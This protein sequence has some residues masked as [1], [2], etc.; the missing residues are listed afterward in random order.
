MTE[1]RK[2]IVDKD[3][4]FKFIERNKDFF[5]QENCAFVNEYGINST[6]VVDLAFFDFNKNYFYGFEIKSESDNLERLYSQ[7]TSYTTFF[8]VVYVVCHSK[9]V[10]GVKKMINEFRHLNKVGIIEVSDDLNFE[11]IKQ[12]KLYKPFYDMFMMNLDLDEVKSI[13]ESKGIYIGNSNKKTLVANMKMSVSI[14]EIYEGMHNKL[15]KLFIRY[16]PNCGSNLYYNKTVNGKHEH[17][18]Y[19]CG[20]I[21]PE[22]EGMLIASHFSNEKGKKIND[23]NEWNKKKSKEEL[24]DLDDWLSE[25][26]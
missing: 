14:E 20:E 11:E 8:N 24:D 7:L 22:E 13:C 4:R 19:N 15:R 17:I 6:N 25:N 5:Q 1:K 21:I 12:A 16:C 9:H 10:E 18:C 2:K 26:T 3:I 23:K